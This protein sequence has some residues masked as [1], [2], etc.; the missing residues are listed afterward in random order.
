MYGGV[1][2]RR[3]FGSTAAAL[4][5]RDRISSSGSADAKLWMT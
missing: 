4:R 2:V 1:R 5:A 3:D